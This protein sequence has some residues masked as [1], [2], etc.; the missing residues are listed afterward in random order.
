MIVPLA[1]DERIV[2]IVN[3]ED[4]IDGFYWIYDS[5]YHGP[6]RNDEEAMNGLKQHERYVE[7]TANSYPGY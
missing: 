3:E 6:Y 2:Q 1:D 7:E 5:C 4:F